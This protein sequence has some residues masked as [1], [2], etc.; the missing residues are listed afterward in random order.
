MRVAAAAAAG[1]GAAAGKEEQ[2]TQQHQQKK[3]RQTNGGWA[4][5]TR[6]SGRDWSNVTGR[7]QGWAWLRESAKQQQPKRT[8][9]KKL[10]SAKAGQKQ[11]KMAAVS[12]QG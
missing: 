11:A 9:E 12:R 3:L 6:S 4:A 2:E 10:S 5:R 8:A 1:G 7:H